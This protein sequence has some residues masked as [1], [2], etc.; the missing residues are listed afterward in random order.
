MQ[1]IKG[2][3][4]IGQQMTTDYGPPIEALLYSSCGTTETHVETH[5]QPVDWD[6]ECRVRAAPGCDL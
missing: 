1:W 4:Q 2:F 5:D 6:S 3:N